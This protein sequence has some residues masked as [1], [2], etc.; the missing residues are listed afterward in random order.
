MF[1][2]VVK[3]AIAIVAFAVVAVTGSSSAQYPDI[4]VRIVGVMN[5]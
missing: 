3:V 1:A 2:A 4:A 5:R